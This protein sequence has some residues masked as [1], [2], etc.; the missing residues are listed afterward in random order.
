MVQE[1]IKLNRNEKDKIWI[2]IILYTT[3]SLAAG[4]RYG[5]PY[6]YNVD[7]WALVRPAVHI[8]QNKTLNPES[9][10]FPG[11]III[12]ILAI[13][14]AGVIG[15]YFLYLHFVTGQANSLSEFVELVGKKWNFNPAA[16][17]CT[18]RIFIACISVVSLVIIYSFVKKRFGKMTALMS[19]LCLVLSPT[20]LRYSC[21]VR[22]DIVAAF[23]IFLSLMYLVK[24]F[25]KQK[26]IHFIF[27][28]MFAGFSVSA[29]YTSGVVAVPLLWGAI[30]SDIRNYTE[31]LN[32]ISQKSVSKNLLF[33]RYLKDSF[34]LKTYFIR[35][36]LLMTIAFFAVSPYVA[37][38]FQ[39]AL[40]DFL[41]EA[42]GDRIGVARLP[43][44]QN[45]IWYLNAIR[46]AL[47][48]LLFFIF[49]CIGLFRIYFVKKNIYYWIF[50][51]FP[52]LYYIIIGFGHLRWIR[53]VIPVLPFMAITF[54]V[55]TTFVLCKIKQWTRQQYGRVGSVVSMMILL[56]LLCVGFRNHTNYMLLLLKEDTRT[57]AKKWVE[58]NIE[59][60]AT[61]ICE[62]YS[63]QLWANPIKSYNIIDCGYKAVLSEP[64]SNY[65]QN[66]GQVFLIISL[67]NIRSKYYLKHPE[68]YQ[69]QLDQIRQI[70]KTYQLVKEF[71]GDENLGPEITI[72]R[73]K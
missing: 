51:C 26:G 43:G 45:H 58:Q 48:G 69:T 61:I 15:F 60:D 27:A 67:T 50:F 9:F 40:Q 49:S 21:M 65:L 63:P 28:C 8:L 11:S 3:V 1:K 44:I 13:I 22:P 68:K 59:T 4:I 72:Y 34:F 53:W 64:L 52:I 30:Y 62:T 66:E 2:I 20:Y 17:H 29:K 73:I 25:E 16:L 47:P 10:I 37:L 36:C 7:D 18:G 39:K 70:Q 35:T 12:Y 71:S 5:L 55:G 31:E 42:N 33:I 56:V 24:Y 14:F 19:I 6:I 32:C 54:G 57:Q 41:F 38:D 23:L 46:L